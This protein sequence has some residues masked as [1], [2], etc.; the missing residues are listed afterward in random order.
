MGK[1]RT[2]ATREEVDI[3]RENVISEIKSRLNIVDTYQPSNA[4]E[5]SSPTKETPSPP[6]ETSN[7]AAGN[8]LNEEITAQGLKVRDLKSNKAEKAEITAAVAVLLDLKAKYKA[9][10]GKDWKPDS[11]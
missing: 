6:E 9:A 11:Q 10:V 3:A 5:P 1:L 2:I 7:A 8:Q 4:K